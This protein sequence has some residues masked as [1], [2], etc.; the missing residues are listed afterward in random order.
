MQYNPGID[1]CTEYWP[2]MWMARVYSTSWLI[3][4][5]ALPIALMTGLY[6]RVVKR[7]WFKKA[8]GSRVTQA[9]VLKSRKRVTK[10]VITVSLVYSITWFPV[11]IIYMLNYF[12]DSQKYGNIVYI[13]GIVIVTLNS[14]VNPF[15]YVF[16]NERFRNHLKRLFR[17]PCHANQT[18]LERGDPT[19][20]GVDSSSQYQRPAIYVA[21]QELARY[22]FRESPC[23]KNSQ[24]STIN[25][26]MLQ[27]GH[28]VMLTVARQYAVRHFRSAPLL[29]NAGRTQ[30][31]FTGLENCFIWDDK[32]GFGFNKDGEVV[33]VTPNT[34]TAN[35]VFNS[36]NFNLTSPELDEKTAEE[37]QI[38]QLI[39]DV[40]DASGPFNASEHH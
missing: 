15:V 24:T 39:L 1:F 14:C 35:P 33:I 40:K 23:N 6:T 4:F 8:Q 36:E 5:G 34:L 16:V 32:H 2:A 30:N 25:M 20:D 12:H 18:N 37:N 22:P 7:L 10:M 27:R 11:L 3:L 29:S 13:V 38:K 21:A 31:E 19:N 17:L 26:A 9:A 28:Q